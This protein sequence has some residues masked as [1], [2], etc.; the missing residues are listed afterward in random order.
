MLT[1]N[2]LYIAQS[3]K[4]RH[5]NRA[6]TAPQCMPHKQ[7]VFAFK[8]PF[9]ALF[10]LLVLCL[11]IALPAHA[12]FSSSEV[13]VDVEYIKRQNVDERL[14]SYGL[15]LLG[16]KVDLNTGALSFGHTDVSIPGNSDLEVAIHRTRTQGFRFPHKDAASNDSLKKTY[17]YDNRARASSPFSDWTLEVPNIS[18]VLPLKSSLDGSKIEAPASYTKN[19]CAIEGLAI[20][21]V[22][23][24][25]T[26]IGGL[27]GMSIQIDT[28][29]AVLDDFEFSNGMDLNIPGIG[30]QKLIDKPKGVGWPSG[31]IKV[32]KNYWTAKCTPA[33]N[34]ATGFVV[35]SPNGDIY[36]FDKFI[37]RA[38]TGI[39]L[40]GK[41]RNPNTG[42]VDYWDSALPR[43][44]GVLQ[45]SEITDVN[46][47]WVRYTYNNRGWVTRIYSN[48]GRDI[49]INIDSN[50]DLIQSIQANGRTWRYEYLTHNGNIFLSK[51]IQ[52]D[53][54]YWA[55]SLQTIPVGPNNTYDCEALDQSASL[56]HPSG[57]S[58][59]FTFSETKHRI[60]Y[61]G[62]NGSESKSCRN[63]SFKNTVYYDFMSV[64]S[65]TLTGPNI[66]NSYWSFSYMEDG[67]V[68]PANTKWGQSVGP[69]G[70]KIKNTYHL[71]DD[72]DGLLY[73]SEHFVS[74][75]SSLPIQT[76]TY[77]YTAEAPVGSTWLQNENPSKFTMPRHQT[78]TITTRDGDT[79]TTESSF[80]TSQSS[81]SYSFG[82]PI[83]TKAYASFY[84][85]TTPRVTDTTYE[86]NKSKWILGLPKTIT[87]NGRQMASYTYDS[88][89]QKTAQTRYGSPHATFGYHANTAYKGALYWV[90]DALG[91]RTYALDWKR[92]TPQRIRRP[93]SISTYQYVDNNGWLTSTKDA[94]G[95]TTSYN[96]DNM[97]RLTLI[98]PPIQS[99]T[100]IS[101]DF[102]GGGAVQTI[103]KGPRTET[104]TYDSMFRPTQTN[105]GGQIYTRSTY[106]ALGQKT[107]ESFPSSGSNPSTGTNYTYDG[108]GRIKT[109]VTSAGTTRHDYYSS[110]RHRV[111]DPS[112]AY[113]TY[114][115]YGYGGPGNKD[116]YAMHHSSGQNTNLFKNV[117]GQIYALQQYG[118]TSGFNVNKIQYFYYDS[119]QRLCRHY[120]PEHGATKYQYNAAGQ[121]TAYAKGQGNSGCGTVPNVSA[122]V[123]QSYDLLGRPTL[124]NFNDPATADIAR[125]Y[126]DNSNLKTVTRG[127]THWSYTYNAGDQL[128]AETLSIDGRSFGLGYGYDGDGR[129]VLQ[130]FP[131]GRVLHQSHDA[132]GR[133]WNLWRDAQ[134]VA[135]NL[136][137]HPD[138]QVAGFYYGN[139]HLYNKT[140]D[141]LLRPTQV[142]HGGGI[143]FDRSYSYDARSLITAIAD[144]V[145][146]SRSQGFS[147]NG[148]GQLTQATGVW[149]TASY[150]YDSLGNIRSKSFT[151]FPGTGSRTL[152]MSYDA[153]N[154]LASYTDTGPG[155]NKTLLHDARGNVTALGALTFIYDLSDQPTA[156]LGGRDRGLQL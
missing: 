2:S 4:P 59:T 28:Q 29:G 70:E 73:K 145:D 139:G 57:V 136:T 128:T 134:W 35:T 26:Q 121:M 47:N 9:I 131:S 80:N 112:G 118:N 58:G 143:L 109:Q 149:G 3:V 82:N 23:R 25:F 37:Y 42:L 129:L 90:E 91:R 18:I 69:L 117:W 83:Q 21:F 72:L 92:G 108:L 13:A 50:T 16:D 89:G 27:G 106:D 36:K 141:S 17:T 152:N 19:L 51:V 84:G 54:R 114:Y 76:T 22:P 97:G 32:T 77:T 55:F 113:M 65:K 43:V 105:V 74:T 71:Y 8:K 150:S 7:S 64:T 96:H 138:G 126:D 45:V 1:Q 39:N 100:H 87:Q 53:N 68:S 6:Y 103:T 62:P 44:K 140:V 14:Q 147:Y 78:K 137:Y 142:T 11:S 24:P 153:Q 93:D 98:D 125:T 111:T 151:N 34:G 30:S 107:F 110:H 155:G 66:P 75:S 133:T 88:F 156:V 144:G 46:G 135:T 130:S 148:L 86:H 101:Y 127:G 67:A 104:I 60:G 38:E 120:V 123:S 94:N 122:K 40:G 5:T 115:S 116:Y 33:D 10:G 81:S 49:R 61:V 15:D 99:S 52:P 124:T 63:G 119:Q 85:S 146:P 20:A 12:Q 48:D 95:N 31:T 56:T 102:S 79:Y 154:R 41:T 132:L